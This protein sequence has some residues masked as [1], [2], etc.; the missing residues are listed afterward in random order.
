MLFCFVTQIIPA[1]D[2]ERC[3]V[4]CFQS[5]VEGKVDD[6]ERE[7]RIVGEIS[8]SMREWDLEPWWLQSGL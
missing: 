4:T 3:P 8:S 2:I 7:G 5:L 6:G 1:S